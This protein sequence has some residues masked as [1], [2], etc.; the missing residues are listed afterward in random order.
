MNEI[1]I[2]ERK[3]LSKIGLAEWFMGTLCFSKC[4]TFT[5]HRLRERIGL[6][7]SMDN[8]PNAKMI[9]VYNK[10]LTVCPP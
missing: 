8:F 1:Q 9:C 2:L 6:V 10:L 5:T 4:S 3:K 7:F